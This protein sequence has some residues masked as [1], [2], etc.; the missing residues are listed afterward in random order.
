MW[1]FSLFAFSAVSSCYGLLPPANDPG[2]FSLQPPY[3]YEGGV[4]CSMD[5][6]C[7]TF[8]SSVNVSGVDGVGRFTGEEHTLTT[9]LGTVMTT[10]VR[11]YEDADISVYET[12]FPGGLEGCAVG[13]KNKV[14]TGFPVFNLVNASSDVDFRYV[15]PGNNMLGWSSYSQGSFWSSHGDFR[16]GEE[17]GIAGFIIPGSYALFLSSLERPMAINNWLEVQN[18][19]AKLHYGIEGLAGSIPPGFSVSVIAATDLQQGSRNSSFVSAVMKWGESV[20]KTFGVSKME[21]PSTEYLGYWTDN[22]A[23]Y[24]YN[25]DTY[26][27]YEDLL[28]AL[29]NYTQLHDIPVRYLQL[30]SWWYFKGLGDGVKNWTAM[31]SVF[32]HGLEA[33]HH[34]VPWPILAHN[35]YF[36]S[37]TSYASLNGG[38]YP[39]FVDNETSKAVPLDKSFWDDLFDEALTWGLAVYEQDWLDEEYEGVSVLHSNVTLGD[40][41]LR[42]MGAAAEERGLP[43]E[44]CMSLPRE[45][46]HGAAENA[47]THLRVSADYSTTPDQW[48]IGHTSLFAHALGLKP[49]KDTFKTNSSSANSAYAGCPARHSAPQGAQATHEGRVNVSE[50]GSPCVHWDRINYSARYPGE[51]LEKNFCRNP[52]MSQDRAYCFTKASLDVPEEQWTWEYCDVL[53]CYTDCFVREG[54]NYFGNQSV[55]EKDYSCVNWNG[56][57][58]LTGTFCRNPKETENRPWCYINDDYSAIDFCNNQ[59]PRAAESN[60]SL[61]SAVATLST[62][63]VGISD[64]IENINQTLVLRSC[65]SDGKLLQPSKPL[66]AIDLYFLSDTR[67]NVWT[68]ETTISAQYTFGLILVAEVATEYNL[69]P[70]QL[71]LEKSLSVPNLVWQH[72]PFENVFSSNL[73]N[74][75]V[76]TPS[77]EGFTNFAILATS[78]VFTVN[79]DDYAILGEVDKWAHVSMDRITQIQTNDTSLL[80]TLEGSAMENVTMHFYL[81][82]E[83]R[84]SVFKVGCTFGDVS[85]VSSLIIDVPSQACTVPDVV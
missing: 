4:L 48:Q 37:D 27:N 6:G 3:L 75:S 1:V 30:D 73:A 51:S 34:E 56:N 68:T 76:N 65:R 64:K 74:S 19:T 22:G 70:S 57:F 59:C 78:P 79:G 72:Y 29:Y 17:A 33:F 83:D 42:N 32:P 38:K 43:V 54:Y 58:G 9:P 21:D 53:A 15:T 11:L 39:F 36:A 28:V 66:T 45:A 81:A 26:D 24:Y 49:F 44:Y 47:V 20:Q 62:G 7:L 2:A 25:T 18:D 71:N 52:A 46:L 8:T 10:L 41:W 31:P 60:P 82:S 69:S 67:P 61:Q 77:R 55:T 35:R 23:Y 80:V 63:P 85:G 16:Y 50:S 14:C 84:E 13:D 40:D 5:N 12:T